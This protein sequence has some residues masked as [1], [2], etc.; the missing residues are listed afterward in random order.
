[1]IHKSI[2]AL[3]SV[4]KKD[5]LAPTNQLGKWVSPFPFCA[6]IDAGLQELCA[7]REQGDQLWPFER[8]SIWRSS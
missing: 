8:S 5:F 2:L 4:C 7:N 3:Y 1:V 6:N